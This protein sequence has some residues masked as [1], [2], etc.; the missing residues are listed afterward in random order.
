M[1]RPLAAL[2][3]VLVCAVPARAVEV[4]ADA[5]A[6]IV[7]GHAARLGAC[8]AGS[9][10]LSAGRI[11][12]RN[13]D[14]EH[15][16]FV[17]MT[18]DGS[19]LSGLIP[20]TRM[21]VPRVGYYF[22]IQ[23]A[24][25][26]VVRTTERRATVIANAT[27]CN[28]LA[29]APPSP[30]DPPFVGATAGAPLTP[31]GFGDSGSGGSL[32]KI[33]GL[34]LLGGG[35]AALALG[36]HGEAAGNAA[37]TAARVPT[38]GATATATATATVTASATATAPAPPGAT[39]TATATRT[40]TAT[41]TATAASATATATSPLRST[42]TATSTARGTATATSTSAATATATARATATPTATP[43]PTGATATATATTAATATASPT[44]AAT[45]TA[46]STPT[47]TPSP[48]SA[49]A[50]P[51]PT[52]NSGESAHRM[53][54]TAVPPLHW[55]SRLD[56]PGGRGQMLLNGELLAGVREGASDGFVRARAGETAV[57]LEIVD[58]HGP[59]Y[60]TITFEGE[61]VSPGSFR[62]AGGAAQTAAGSVVLRVY[63]RPGERAA[64]TFHSM[65]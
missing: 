10:K 50:T 21:N 37:P 11:Y 40:A 63:G 47:V 65:R 30:L 61:G 51:T 46:T 55:R 16:Y 20:K 1:E 42:A 57:E 60:W 19:C 14:R 33:G 62:V 53:S 27:E 12:F 32:L 25:G 45:A 35:G 7:R 56:V 41:A 64:F 9:T 48:S 13:A 23:P 49:T 2:A 22:E 8:A 52:T 59:G 18:H 54:G 6:C 31:Q 5:P 39:A 3:C 38:N 17:D 26:S 4:K 28:G 58:A 29:V 24:D 15:W 43:S 44:A 36:H 34:A